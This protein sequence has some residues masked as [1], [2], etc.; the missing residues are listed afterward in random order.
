MKIALEFLTDS[1]LKEIVNAWN[2]KSRREVVLVNWIQCS[3]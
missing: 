1:H 3:V 2:R